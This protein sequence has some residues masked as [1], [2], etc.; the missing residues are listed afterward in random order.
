[1]E[2]FV[3]KQNNKYLRKKPAVGGKFWDFRFKIVRKPLKTDSSH[4]IRSRNV[5][6]ISPAA[7]CSPRLLKNLVVNIVLGNTDLVD[8]IFGVFQI[9][10]FLETFVFKG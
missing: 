6:K 5:K 2:T 4:S 7:G 9:V 8:I 10:S 3:F 1:M